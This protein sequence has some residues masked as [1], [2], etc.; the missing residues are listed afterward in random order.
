MVF[1]VF[2]EKFIDLGFK[3]VITCVDSKV[4]DKS[5]VG[6]MIDYDLLNSLP[7]N[8]DPCGENG[9]FHS[10]VFDG[11][12]FSHPLNIELKDKILID[13]HWFIDIIQAN[14]N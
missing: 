1:N 9:E 6:K 3:A 2:I 7:P 8:V 11:P 13:D 12:I 4:L 10:F 14:P 5:F